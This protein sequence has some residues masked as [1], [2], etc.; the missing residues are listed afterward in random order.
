MNQEESRTPEV[1]LRAAVESA[2]SGLLMVDQ[3]GRIVLVNREIERLFGYPR[4]ELLGKS[5]DLLVP[6]ALRAGHS[7]YRSEFLSQPSVRAMGAG[8]D[9]Y[10][11]RKDG[12][13]VPVEIGLTPVATEDGMFI[14][15]SIVDISAR[16]RAEARFRAAVE[17]SPA[18]MVMVDGGG[19]IVLVN[20]A[21]ERMFGYGREE[22]MGESIE[23]LVP[24]R[25]RSVHPGHRQGF[26]RA[27]DARAMGAGRDLFGLRK[28]GTEIPVEIGLNPIETDDGTFVLSSIV[29]ISQRKKEEAEREE[30]E[31]QLRQAQKMDAVGTL[32]GGIAHDFNN[33]LGA[34]LGFAELLRDSVE[35]H[36][37]H[38][39][40][41]ELLAF[42]LR[43]KSLVEKIQTFGRRTERE[44]HPVS[45]EGPIR[46]VE[47]L[48]RSSFP[49]TVEISVS[50]HPDTPRVLADPTAM[51]QVLMNLGLNAG[52][53]MP[54]GGKIRIQVAPLYVADSRA[55]AHPLLTEGPHVVLSVADTGTGID[56]DLQPRVFEPFFTTKPPGKGSGLG[57]AIIHGIVQEHRGAVELES[58][59]GEGTVIRVILPAVES[60]DLELRRGHEE[61]ERGAGERILYVDDEPGLRALGK[62]RLERLGYELVVAG[63]GEE[64]LEIFRASPEEFD[65]VM[66]D[67]LMPRMTGL[68]LASAI[69]A[70]RAEIPILLLTGFVDHLPEEEIRAGGVTSI[71]RKP[72]SG[73]DLAAAIRAVLHQ[74]SNG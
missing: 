12:T 42:T 22:L 25:F 33:I 26:F 60:D 59:P 2:P 70:I 72:I 66:T 27:P 61:L 65:A 52:Q 43:G 44:R 64:A 1:R 63:D 56:P 20:K 62:R 71:L 15:S 40:L 7:D 49:P 11:R 36:Q 67:Y 13:Q 38:R 51:H 24:E 28:D 35:G 5:V 17:S 54:T 31:L 32:A 30:L 74:P 14:L 69:S 3:D 39:D 73:Q 16:R 37:A 41:D 53:A 21:V 50:V 58:S 6:E 4:E 57:L 45:I 19:S 9:L 48:L 10:G 68:E 55:R 47:S 18:G 29:D 8:R 46:E 34:I 23:K